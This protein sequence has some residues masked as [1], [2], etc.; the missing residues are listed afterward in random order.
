MFLLMNQLL[1]LL[2]WILYIILVTGFK[3]KSSQ[4]N[5]FKKYLQ[6]SIYLILAS[7]PMVIYLINYFNYSFN[8]KFDFF[9]VFCS[10]IIISALFKISIKKYVK[11]LDY[12]F[13]ITKFFDILFQQLFILITI[14]IL[15]SYFSNKLHCLIVFSLFFGLIH[16]FTLFSHPIGRA[17]RFTAFSFLGGT[18]FGYLILFYQNGIYYSFGVHYVFYLCLALYTVYN[19]KSTFETPLN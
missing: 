6:T 18:I 5:Y 17:L 9:L 13:L 2:F 11:R 19:P 3:D 8:F 1:M 4:L 12:R 15:T 14:F 16:L 7:I 10:L